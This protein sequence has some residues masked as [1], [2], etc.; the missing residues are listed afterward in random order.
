MPPSR[1]A[2]WLAGFAL[3]AAGCDAHH[4]AATRPTAADPPPAVRGDARPTVPK[5]DLTRLRYDPT[6]RTLVLYPLAEAGGR[7]MLRTAD[8]PVGVPVDREV[9]FADGPAPDLG[10]VAVF[11]TVP[12]RGPSPAVSLRE[13]VDAHAGRVMR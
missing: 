8:D 6:A 4:Q 7:W 11:Y 13:I 2:R 9:T 12:N 10:A 1:P 5:P 3:A